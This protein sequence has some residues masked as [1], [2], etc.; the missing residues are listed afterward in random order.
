MVVSGDAE[1][2]KEPSISP[3]TGYETFGVVGKNDEASIGPAT[4]TRSGRMAAL[5]TRLRCSSHDNGV[6]LP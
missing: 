3:F 4:L 6:S 2:T 5:P 1:L